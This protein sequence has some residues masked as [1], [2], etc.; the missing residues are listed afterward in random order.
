MNPILRWLLNWAILADEWLNTLTLGD[1][2]ETVSSRAGKAMLRKVL[3]ACILCKLLDLA[4]KDHCLKAIDAA[5]GR[6]A[7]DPD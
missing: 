3:W 7:I 4:Q 6:R 1:P 2:G 5:D